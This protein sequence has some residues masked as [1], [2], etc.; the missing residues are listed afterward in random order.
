VTDASTAIVESMCAL[1]RAAVGAGLVVGSGGNLSARVPGADTCWVTGAGTWLG[2]LTSKDF[3][4]VRIVDGT[5]VAGDAPPSTEVALHLATY[6]VRPDVNAV[7]HLHPQLA[8]LLDAFGEPVRLITT[9][10]AYYLRRVARTPF[11]PPGTAE[12]AAAAAAAVAD[13]TNCVILA[14]HGCSVLGRD[15]PMAHRRASNLDEAARM[16]YRALLLSGGLPGRPIV[17]CPWD[18]PDDGLI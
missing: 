17:D 11:H 4:E 2:R 10:H 1:G 18:L 5:V 15:V 13:G 12:L 7:V 14:H 8:V 3:V 9:D 16:T 6:R